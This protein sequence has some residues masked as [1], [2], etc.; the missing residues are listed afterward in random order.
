MSIE[1]ITQFFGMAVTAVGAILGY[2]RLQERVDQNDRELNL[3][4]T[5]ESVQ[6]FQD[7]VLRRLERIERTID[8]EFNSAEDN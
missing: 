3:V 6:P 5:K 1:D 2:G 4:A 7:E 8:R